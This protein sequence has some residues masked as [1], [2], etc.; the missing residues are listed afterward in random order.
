MRRAEGRNKL[1]LGL[2]MSSL[3][4]LLYGTVS[5]LSDWI[6]ING[7]SICICPPANY[8]SKLDEHLIYGFCAGIC[9]I[10]LFTISRR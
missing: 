3:F 5:F 1:K 8:L 10:I 2:K 4:A 9:L 7:W 6:E